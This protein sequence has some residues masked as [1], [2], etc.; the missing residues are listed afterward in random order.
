[1]V[2]ESVNLIYFN[3]SIIT[4]QYC[5]GFCYTSTWIDHRYTR[6]P[7]HPEPPSRLPPHPIPVGC[8]RA[9]TLGALLHALNLPWSSILHMVIYVSML[10]PQIIPPLPP[11]TESKSLFL[12]LC[13]LCC[14][15]CRIVSTIF[16]NSIYVCINI[17]YFIYMYIHN[18]K[19]YNIKVIHFQALKPWMASRFY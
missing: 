9:L 11:S 1:M 5:D 8:P 15:A 18:I 17:Q 16:L 19:V 7:P 12:H 6:V 3:W 2:L 13:L 10:F 4:L 14:P